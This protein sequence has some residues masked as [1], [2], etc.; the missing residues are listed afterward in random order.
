[1]K[2]ELRPPPCEHPPSHPFEKP[3]S[4]I[5][6]QCLPTVVLT[7]DTRL[8]LLV[9]SRVCAAVVSLGEAA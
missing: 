4:K 7:L 1:M 2:R 6:G 9:V 3:T 8:V 5:T